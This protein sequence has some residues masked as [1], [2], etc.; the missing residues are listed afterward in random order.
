MLT[1]GTIRNKDDILSAVLGLDQFTKNYCMNIAETQSKCDL[2]F[3]CDECE[4]SDKDTEKC[5]IK[6]FVNNHV[7]NDEKLNRYHHSEQWDLYK[8]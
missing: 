6:D 4:F 5:R 1:I 3:R 2:V 8:I 7:K